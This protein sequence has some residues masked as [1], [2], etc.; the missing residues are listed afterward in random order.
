MQVIIGSLIKCVEYKRE[1]DSFAWVNQGR[2]HR[3]ADV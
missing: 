1:S 2:L 3:E